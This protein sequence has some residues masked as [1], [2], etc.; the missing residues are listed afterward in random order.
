M[1]RDSDQAAFWPVKPGGRGVV[2]YN[3]KN[4]HRPQDNIFMTITKGELS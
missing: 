1:K 2:E 4:P 3:I